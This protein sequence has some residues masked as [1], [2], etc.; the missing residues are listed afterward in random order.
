MKKIFEALLFVVALV[1]FL[2]SCSSYNEIDRDKSGETVEIRSTFIT[3]DKLYVFT[4]SNDYQFEDS[5]VD[6]LKNFAASKYNEKIFYFSS[7]LNVINENISGNYIVYIDPRHL[8][9]DE[10][11]DLT[12]N[13]D[14]SIR[15]YIENNDTEKFKKL[16]PDYQNK[17]FLIG[18][19]NAD[20][21]I[22]NISNRDELISKYALKKPITAT[23]NYYHKRLEFSQKSKDVAIMPLQ[24][25][26]LLIIAPVY[27]I[28]M[29]TCDNC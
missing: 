8:S 26:T 19:Y 5:D 27:L 22:I 23:V 24:A 9:K 29:A 16:I 11:D 1:L 20:G 18:Y 6:K 12:D 2:S 15:N 4:D 17:Y 7:T 10:I 3:D 25:M 14:F 21:K 13:Y 28:I